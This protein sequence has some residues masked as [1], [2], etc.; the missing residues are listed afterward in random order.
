MSNKHKVLL[1]EDDRTIADAVAFCL[2]AEGLSVE[3]AANGRDGLRLATKGEHQVLILDLMLPD[4]DDREIC[5]AVRAKSQVPILM[6]TA[7][8]LEMDKVQGLELGADD[9]LTKPFGMREFVARVKALLRRGAGRKQDPPQSY[10]TGVVV[11]D[12]ATRGVTVDGA[13]VE[14]RRK[15]FDLLHALVS[16][17]GRVLTRDSLLERVWG[18]SDFLSTNTLDVHI[19]W[20]RQKIER[21]PSQ[22]H[23]I[24]TV[25]GIGY[26]YGEDDD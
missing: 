9:Y 7:R 24:L 10:T 12:M 26:K 4:L 19:R 16:N 5:R 2:R 3:H 6:L 11:I 18:Q 20:L 13:P 23:R 22:P 21:D 25:R 15:E 1:V 14:L 8:A 17:R